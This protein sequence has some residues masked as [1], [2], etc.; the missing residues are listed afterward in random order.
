MEMKIIIEIERFVFEFIFG[1]LGWCRVLSNFLNKYFV[2][3]IIPLRGFRWFIMVGLKQKVKKYIEKK[4][5]AI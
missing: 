1:G 5:P 2:M 4:S 3:L